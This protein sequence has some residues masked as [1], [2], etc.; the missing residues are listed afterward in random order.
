[1][2]S[3]DGASV[4]FVATG[5]DGKSMIWVRPLNA[6]EAHMLAGTEG[7]TFPFWSPD[8]HHGL[9]GRGCLG[10]DFCGLG[11]SGITDP[12][13]LSAAT[14]KSQNPHPT[15]GRWD[16]APYGSCTHQNAWLGQPP[17]LKT[18]A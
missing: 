13:I 1:V 18:V 6:A 7:A 3:P 16:G 9:L 5:S 12:T 15:K 17:Q 11:R 2:L 4:A 10:G 14:D 8:S